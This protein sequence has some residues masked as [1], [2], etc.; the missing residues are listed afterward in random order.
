[1]TM[2]P[3][4]Q[5]PQQLVSLPIAAGILGITYE[6]A[7]KRA[8]RTGVILPGV[9]VHRRA[10][11]AHGYVLRSDIERALDSTVGAA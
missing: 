7:R 5:Q 1:M 3:C 2:I 6:A 10:R 11:R 4:E 9:P 8:W